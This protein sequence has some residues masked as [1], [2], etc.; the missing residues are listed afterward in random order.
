M[1]GQ[2]AEP[3][4]GASRSSQRQAHAGHWSHHRA[5]PCVKVGEEPL[6]LWAIHRG[7]STTHRVPPTPASSSR[8]RSSDSRFAG[9]PSEQPA[10]RDD[11][12]GWGAGQQLPGSGVAHRAPAVTGQSPVPRAA[13]AAQLSRCTSSRGLGRTPHHPHPLPSDLACFVLCLLMAVKVTSCDKGISKAT[14]A[15]GHPCSGGAAPK[16]GPSPGLPIVRG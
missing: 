16:C 4:G 3:V 10:P 6:Q 11:R 5:P 15:S 12:Q 7:P 14:E 1:V 8:L 9:G 2:K 13:C